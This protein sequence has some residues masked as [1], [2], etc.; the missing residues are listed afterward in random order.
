M[1]YWTAPKGYFS[2]S[3]TVVSSTFY[4][5]TMEVET[6]VVLREAIEVL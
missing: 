5:P 6:L 4:M 2:W 1:Q 3:L